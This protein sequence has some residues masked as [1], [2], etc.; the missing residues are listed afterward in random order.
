M[1]SS[2]LEQ[3]LDENINTTEEFNKTAKKAE[4][5]LEKNEK[6]WHQ[7]KQLMLKQ[8][9]DAESHRNQA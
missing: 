5:N 7:E 4:F 6:R 9:T 1:K 3:K 8:I 2:Y